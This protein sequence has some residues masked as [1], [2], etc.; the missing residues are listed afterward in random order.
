MAKTLNV[1]IGEVKIASRGE[2]LKAILGSCIG[3]GL[4]W[5]QKRICG[6]SHCLLPKNP[7]PYDT[8]GGRYI[9]QA[10]HSL[11]TMME[12]SAIDFRSIDA[13]VVGGGNMTRPHA[14]DVSQLVGTI[15]FHTALKEV[16][17]RGITIV[18]SDGGGNYGRK[19][20]I[21]SEL[22]YQVDLIPRITR[23]N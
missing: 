12:I 23:V 6:L 16:Q 19:I 17:D 15:N 9:D 20:L 21:D 4:I 2:I 8:M 14:S 18:H 13:V 11:I 1:H 22:N 5:R 10:V 3:I 7:E